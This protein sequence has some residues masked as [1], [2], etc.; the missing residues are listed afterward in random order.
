VGMLHNVSPTGYVPF[1]LRPQP[2]ETI[3]HGLFAPQAL[4]EAVRRM[5]AG[6]G[7]AGEER[8]KLLIRRNAI[9]RQMTNEAEIAE[10]L[11]ARGFIEVA[12]ERLSL[13]EQVA[14]Y[15]RARMVVGATGAAMAN[16]IFCQPDCPIVILMMKFRETAYWYWRGMAAAAGAGPVL[17][18]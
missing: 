11:V 10:A 13:D 16:L 2:L 15:S 5:R 12:P 8:P 4:R 14:L 7:G 18:V 1:K 17:H 6:V 3:G 9:V